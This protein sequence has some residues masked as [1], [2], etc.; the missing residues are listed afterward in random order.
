MKFVL[1]LLS[2]V[3]VVSQTH[4]EA[5]WDDSPGF[6]KRSHSLIPPHSGNL[7]L[8]ELKGDTMA[9]SE[10][11]R[12]TA[13]MQSKRGGLWSRVVSE[14]CHCR[15]EL[16]WSPLSAGLLPLVGNAAQFQ[17]SWL[18]KVHC[19]RRDGIVP[20]QRADKVRF[21]HWRTRDIYRNGSPPRLLQKRTNDGKFSA[22]IFFLRKRW[23]LW[24]KIC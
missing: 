5:Y 16:L 19:R 22:G 15:N 2:S 17:N 8:W 23:H 10:H 13:D 24:S 14:Q 4:G 7:P 12:L 18:G 6:L 1:L 3:V 11:I 20:H 9:T 21:G